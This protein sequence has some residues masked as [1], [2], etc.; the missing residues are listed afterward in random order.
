MIVGGAFSGVPSAA[1]AARPGSISRISLLAQAVQFPTPFT[2]TLFPVP[3]WVD[4]KSVPNS[5]S[6][7]NFLGDLRA[8][9]TYVL[10]YPQ[11]HHTGIRYPK[12]LAA[13]N[14]CGKGLKNEWHTQMDRNT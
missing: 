14:E 7:S 5:F 8:P 6:P 4:S 1:N 13:M 11:V 12:R 9:L 2:R 3:Y 10:S